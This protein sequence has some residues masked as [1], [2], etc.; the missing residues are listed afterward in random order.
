MRADRLDPEGEPLGNGCVAQS[1]GD[2]REHLLLADRQR[3]T[4][5]RSGTAALRAISRTAAG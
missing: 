3:L 4:G 2:E 1:L 5:I